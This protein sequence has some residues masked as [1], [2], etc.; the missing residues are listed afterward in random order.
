MKKILNP[1]QWLL[2]NENDNTILVEDCMLKYSMY[3]S[4][5]FAK[6][7]DKNYYQGENNNY[8][9]CKEDFGGKETSFNIKQLSVIFH[10]TVVQAE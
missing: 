8:A 2:K 10:A 9:K 3:V 5:E 1:E 4:F 7:I 6:W